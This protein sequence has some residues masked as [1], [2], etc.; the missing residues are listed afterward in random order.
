VTSAGDG[1][2]ACRDCNTVLDKEGKI[3]NGHSCPKQK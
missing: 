3:G 2:S 1:Q